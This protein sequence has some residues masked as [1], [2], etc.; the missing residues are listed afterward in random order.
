MNLDDVV[1]TVQEYI[2]EHHPDDAPIRLTVHLRSGEKI[3]LPISNPAALA[4]CT[5]SEDFRSI[6]WYG[7][8]YSFTALQAAIIRILWE[9]WQKE[10]PEVGQGVLLETAGSTGSRV[11]DLFRAHPAWDDGMIGPGSRGTFR[12]YAPD[13]IG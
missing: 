6:R 8:P 11:R 13:E 12:L 2:R 5:H 3:R 10:A 4:P 1:R 7:T 9:A